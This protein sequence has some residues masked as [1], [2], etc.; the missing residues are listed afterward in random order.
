MM[1]KPKTTQNII[2]FGIKMIVIKIII[3]SHI[4][5]K[6]EKLF[7]MAKYVKINGKLKDKQKYQ[8]AEKNIFNRSLGFKYFKKN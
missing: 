8:Y 6:S 2:K 5:H 4:S 3:V 1:P 7:I